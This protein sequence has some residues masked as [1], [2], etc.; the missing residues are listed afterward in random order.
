MLS[1]V[2]GALFVAIGVKGFSA[3]GLPLSKT[4]QLTGTTGKIVGS[5]CFLLGAAYFIA[6]FGLFPWQHP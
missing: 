2:L 4:K 6:A 1:L 5:I 3:A